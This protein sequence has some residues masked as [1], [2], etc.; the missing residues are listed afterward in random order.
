MKIGILGGGQVGQALWEVIQKEN[1]NILNL[2]GE[3]LDIVRVLVRNLSRPRIIPNFYL[4][5]KVE[6]I[7]DNPEIKLVIEVMGGE[8]PAYTFIKRAIENGK[9]VVTA[10][11]EIIALYGD[12]LFKLARKKGV[13]L[14]FEASVGGG[15]PVIKA[16]KEGLVVD[17]IK[18]IWSILNGTTNYILTK[19]EENKSDFSV[20]LKEAQEKGYA[21]PDP[22]KDISGLDSVYKIA[23]LSSLAFHTTIKPMDIFREG[24]EKITLRDIEYAKSLGY[25]IK[26]LALAREDNGTLEIRVH[27]TMIP[28]NHMLSAVRGV[29]NA[30]LFKEERRGNIILYGPGAGPKPTAM[31]LLSDILELSYSIIHSHPRYYN[32]AYLY[33]S[34]LKPWGEIKTRYYL[35][36]WV[37][38]K[39]GV[40]AQIAKVLGE[41]N[42]SIASVIQK[43]T[44]IE[45]EKAEIVIL[46]HVTYEKDIQ[47][48][49]SE[50]QKLPILEEWNS[51]I[52]IEV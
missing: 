32:F 16:I 3:P 27:P 12:E 1:E 6:E 20:V 24:I 34:N 15:I 37:Q 46:T 44:N 41:N 2:L 22:Y 52:R 25:S 4:T 26:L 23:I 50:I 21:E 13:D 17:K 29:N 10:N 11:K 8:E 45:N 14:G 36:F 48:A 51:L 38:D 49:I 7:I 40:L 9:Y 43:E 30:V 33:P 39:P 47:K 18:E 42:I 19:M 35:R 31:A 28:Q 5:T